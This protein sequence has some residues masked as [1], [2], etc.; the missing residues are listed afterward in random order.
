VITRRTR[1][2]AEKPALLDV[3]RD[4]N[5]R[6]ASQRQAFLAY[7]QWLADRDTDGT[8]PTG[9]TVQE[10]IATGHITVTRRDGYLWYEAA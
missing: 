7:L 3:M 10:A 8:I 6:S 9:M 1:S 5:A 4:L 2:H